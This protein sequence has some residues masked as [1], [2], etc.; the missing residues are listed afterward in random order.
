MQPSV[1][2]GGLAPALNPAPMARV[3]SENTMVIAS[4]FPLRGIWTAVCFTSLTILP[5]RLGGVAPLHGLALSEVAPATCDKF[6]CW[7][8]IDSP[9]GLTVGRAT[10]APDVAK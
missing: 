4:Y 7:I 6:I 2:S 3:P 1:V 10:V 9:L 5:A 8:M